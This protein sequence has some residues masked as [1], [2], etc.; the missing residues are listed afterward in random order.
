MRVIDIAIKHDLSVVSLSVIIRAART[1][2]KITWDGREDRSERN[3]SIVAQ[4]ESGLT[5]ESIAK[6][7]N[8]SRE[9]VRQILADNGVESRS[10]AKANEEAYKRWVLE[11][12]DEVNQSFDVNRSINRTIAASH[13]HSPT[14][15]RR[16]L[17][18]RKHESIWTNSSE[19]FWNKERLLAVLKDASVDGILTIPR[20]QKWRDSG[21]KFEG[22]TPPTHA[23]IVWTFG[24]WNNALL[25]AGLTSSGRNN[26]RVY[27][28]TWSVDD[29]YS[30]VRIY[31]L[32][33]KSAGRR[34]TFAGYGEWSH[35]NPGHPSNTY[36][37]VL[38]NKPWSEVLREVMT[39]TSES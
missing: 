12:G 32:E 17:S 39:V 18:D 27:S 8:I 19:K 10:L 35:E 1:L 4:Y 7:Y 21:V 15:I 3:R 33:M 6:S 34:P 37:R 2:G 26:N 31:S 22:R 28:R 25:E 13:T 23:I 20:Y 14:W 16:F 5:M 9:R 38:T 11:Y 24:S 29:A 30:A 36:I